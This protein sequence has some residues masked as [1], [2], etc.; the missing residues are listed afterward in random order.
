LADA[1]VLDQNTL[2]RL[3]NL[4]LYSRHCYNSGGLLS[5]RVYTMSKTNRYLNGIR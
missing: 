5:A 4:N 1:V 2:L 3:V